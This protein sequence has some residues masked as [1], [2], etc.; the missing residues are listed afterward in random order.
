MLGVN[1]ESIV[2]EVRDLPTTLQLL[3]KLRKL[4]HHEM[5]MMEDIISVIKMDAPLAARV[6]KTSNSAYYGGGTPVESLME[7]INRLGFVE[8]C[9]ITESVAAKHA[10]NTDIS[11][12]KLKPGELWEKSITSAVSMELLGKK[13]GVPTD[14]AYTIGLLHTIGK[15]VI[16][17][18]YTE[19]GMEIYSEDRKIE[20]TPE[21]EKQFLGFTHTEVGALLL[22]KWNFAE[23]IHTAIRY[24]L[25]PLKA[26]NHQI[27]ACLAYVAGVIAHWLDEDREKIQDALVG[28]NE[29]VFGA[30]LKLDILPDLFDEVLEKRENALNSF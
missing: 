13:V 5:S 12:Y 18:Y 23:V 6:L 19:R 11:T 16:N 20:L 28:N 26:Q 1:L 25:D 4:L 21:M 30:K 8:V 3:P 9:R 27:F 24:Q 2:E 22:E 17:Q 7:A 14:T 10:L 29:I 15:L